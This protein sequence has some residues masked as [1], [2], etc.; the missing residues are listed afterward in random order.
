MKKKIKIIV[1]TIAVLI[2]ICPLPS[3]KTVSLGE[4]TEVIADPVEPVKVELNPAL[5]RVCSCE[6]NG[7]PDRE[8]R[9]FEDDG[10]TVRKGKINPLDTGMCQINLKYHE[11]SAAK[12]SL[13]LFKEQDNIKY[14]N[15][16]YKN[17]GLTPWNWSKQC[18]AE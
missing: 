9:H 4:P 15:W 2:L 1:Y 8:P 12:M 6:S 5:K 13:D 10:V 18:W 11:A 17:E 14:A 16:L 7:R 3:D